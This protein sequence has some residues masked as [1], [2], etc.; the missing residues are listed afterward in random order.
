MTYS[1]PVC[2]Y[3]YDHVMGYNSDEFKEVKWSINSLKIQ[4]DSVKEPE[5][6]TYEVKYTD[7]SE[8]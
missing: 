8:K 7:S 1:R 3:G 4:L 6:D 5:A 2:F